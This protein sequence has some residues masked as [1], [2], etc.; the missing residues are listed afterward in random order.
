MTLHFW[1]HPGF[2]PVELCSIGCARVSWT[3]P[4]PVGSDGCRK[5]LGLIGL[6]LAVKVS[7]EITPTETV[8][9]EALALRAN[10][11]GNRGGQCLFACG[12]LIAVCAWA[13]LMRNAFC[14]RCS[15]V[16]GY[17]SEAVGQPAASPFHQIVRGGAS[18]P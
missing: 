13:R 14:D 8:S 12:R 5:L 18:K 2:I 4:G 15:F 10:V 11:K 17:L 7:L 9:Q 16:E 1:Q 6:L 3:I